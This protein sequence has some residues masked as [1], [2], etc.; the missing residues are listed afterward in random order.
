MVVVSHGVWR[1]MYALATI[2]PIPAASVWPS[3]SS[4]SGYVVTCLCG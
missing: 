1:V 4:D 3:V 2:D